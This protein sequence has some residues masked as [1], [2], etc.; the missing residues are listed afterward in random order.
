MSHVYLKRMCILLL[1]DGV[2]YKVLVGWLLWW[3]ISCT[4]LTGLRG[5]QI[6]CKI[7]CI[8]GYFQIYLWGCF[9]K[10]FKSVD[11]VKKMAFTNA[12]GVIQSPGGLKRTKR[13][14]KDKFPLCL[15]QDIYLLRSL[16][17]S[18][19]GSWVLG[20]SNSDEDL[21]PLAS[22]VLKPSGLYWNYTTSFPGPPS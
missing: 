18:T 6:T 16:D 4:N 19:S 3:L 12:G 2:F 17:I 15:S 20:L 9:W 1:F 22:L 14:R 21:T 8:S 5:V 11:W 7:L 10:T 13:G